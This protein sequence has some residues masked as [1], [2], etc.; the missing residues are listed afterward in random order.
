[1]SEKDL[2]SVPLIDKV[3]DKF[4]ISYLQFLRMVYADRFIP[5]FKEMKKSIGEA[6]LI[7]TL[8]RACCDVAEQRIKQLTIEKDFETFKAPIKSNDGFYQH[9]TTYEVL[10]DTDDVLEIKVTECLWAD[11]YREAGEAELGYASVCHQD[12]I[13]ATA[14]NPKLKLIRDKTLMQGHDCCNHRWVFEK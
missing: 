9:T 14:F 3:N 4:D 12:F 7:E 11:M 5:I 10:E 13:A 2:K 1:M 8:G 6:K